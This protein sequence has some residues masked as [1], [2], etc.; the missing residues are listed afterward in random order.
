M[1]CHCL[2]SYWPCLE[3]LLVPKIAALNLQDMTQ[4]L[5]VPTAEQAASILYR[6]VTENQ[7]RLERGAFLRARMHKEIKSGIRPQGY[8]VEWIKHVAM[9]IIELLSDE[10]SSFNWIF[11]DDRVSVADFRDVICT[12]KGM[13]D[14]A[15]GVEK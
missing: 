11:G 9:E 4:E 8:R 12:V 13:L 7:K 2:R 6:L 10:G 5:Q 1:E 15:E 3:G 14:Q